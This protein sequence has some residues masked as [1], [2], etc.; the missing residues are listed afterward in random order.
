VIGDFG[1]VI[2]NVWRFNVW[3]FN[4]WRFKRIDVHNVSKKCGL[5]RL[6]LG[7]KGSKIQCQ[8]NTKAKIIIN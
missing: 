6:V 8:I 3:R 2:R 5:H 4:V 7:V 1:F